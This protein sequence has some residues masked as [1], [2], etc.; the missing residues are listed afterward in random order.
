[1]A[2][3]TY[4]YLEFRKPAFLYNHSLLV[5][6]FLSFIKSSRFSSNFDHLFSISSLWRIVFEI[7]NDSKSLFSLSTLVHFSFS[8]SHMNDSCGFCFPG[9][10]TVNSFRMPTG[11]PMCAAKGAHADQDTQICHLSPISICIRF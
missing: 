3:T 4:S 7:K 2:E 6:K 11:S 5:G 9:I 10:K 1:M 8:I